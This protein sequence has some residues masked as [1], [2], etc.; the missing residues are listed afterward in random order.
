[1]T[2]SER[3]LAIPVLGAWANF[4]YWHIR[5]VLCGASRDADE[6]ARAQRAARPSLQLP[7]QS[8][9]VLSETEISLQVQISVTNR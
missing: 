7:D 6:R 9:T 3:A 5:E 2:P 8:S 4:I 1:M